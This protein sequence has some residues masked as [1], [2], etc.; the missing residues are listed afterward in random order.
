MKLS[1]FALVMGLLLPAAHAEDWPQWRG[2]TGQGIG[3]AKA[4]PT[5]WSETENIGW[6]TPLRGKAWS[7]PVIL[8][9]EIW[10]TTA[11]EAPDTPENIERRLK[12]N[13]GNQ[14]L[15]L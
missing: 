11:E 3:T 14:P 2:P 4:T 10:L 15:N 6:K 13:T 12:A 5:T 8:G 7:S 9:D 1:L